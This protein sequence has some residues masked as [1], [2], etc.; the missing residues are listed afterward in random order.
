MKVLVGLASLT[1]LVSSAGC[2]TNKDDA[3]EGLSATDSVMD[4]TIAPAPVAVPVAYQPPAEPVTYQPAVTSTPAQ[5]R[6]TVKKGDT[7]WR[8]AA[9]EYGDGKQWQRIAQANPGV[10][11]TSLKVGQTL[12]IP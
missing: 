11:A 2:V 7:Y 10:H 1:L 4:L 12:V 3:A 6:Y 5:G 9:S 8:I